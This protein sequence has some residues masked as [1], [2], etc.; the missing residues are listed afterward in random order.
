MRGMRR[1]GRKMKMKKACGHS[2]MEKHA[3]PSRS[4]LHVFPYWH[5]DA[6]LNTLNSGMVQGCPPPPQPPCVHTHTH[7]HPLFPECSAD[8]SSQ[9]GISSQHK[10]V[11]Q[12]SR[13]SVASSPSHQTWEKQLSQTLLPLPATVPLSSSDWPSSYFSFTLSPLLPPGFPESGLLQRVDYSSEPRLIKTGQDRQV[14][15]PV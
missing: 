5:K 1:G 13:D 3:G 4:S 8:K 10:H 6:A 7:P 9:S 14:Q 12:S 2:C 15:L 11:F